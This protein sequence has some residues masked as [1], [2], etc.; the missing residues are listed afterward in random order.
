MHLKPFEAI[1]LI[2]LIVDAEGNPQNVCVKKPAGYGL[3]GQA[4]R[5]VEQYRSDPATRDGSP[6][7]VRI[8]VEVNFRLY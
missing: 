1:S 3:D 2:T 5:A 6:V 8:S 4:V 7:P